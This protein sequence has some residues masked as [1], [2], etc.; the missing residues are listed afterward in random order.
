LGLDQKDLAAAAEVT[1]S[2]LESGHGGAQGRPG[3]G[4]RCRDVCGRSHGSHP[5]LV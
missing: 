4:L 1:E 3:T 2:C 5:R